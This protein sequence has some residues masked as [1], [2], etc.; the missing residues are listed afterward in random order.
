MTIQSITSD[1]TPKQEKQ[2]KRFVED[3][4]NR[5]LVEVDPDKDAI[6]RL[7]SR[8]G[9][10]QDY[11]IAGIRRFTAKALNYTRARTILGKDFISPEDIMK[12]RKGVVY[13][14]DQ[15]SWFGDTVPSQEVL[16]WCRDNGHM[17]TA[18]PN[19]SMS[20]L[21]IRSLKKDYFYSK[22]GGWYAEQAFAQNDKVETRWIMLRKEPVPQS[23]SKTW[24]KQ[25][26]LL[27]ENEVTP[28]AAEVVWCLTTYK[29]VRNTYLL[30]SVDARTSSV[31]S[32]GHRVNVGIFDRHGLSVSYWWDGRRHDNL[33]VSSARKS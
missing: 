33:G 24:G 13:T 2:F 11:L 3:A 7:I 12:S 20:L 19:R 18:G 6:Q 14:D 22:E 23:T 17:L 27:N 4:V 16:E 31:D 5:G 1:R 29:A 10:F 15:L 26:T 32:V 30:P 8:G 21:E 28:N 25:Q 9:E